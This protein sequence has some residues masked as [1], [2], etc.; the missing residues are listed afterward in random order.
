[1]MK[2]VFESYQFTDEIP[3]FEY[4]KNRK[5]NKYFSRE[6]AAAIVTCGK[7]LKGQE[8]DPEI[9]V[10]YATGVVEFEDYGLAKIVTAC[11]D[12]NNRYWPGSCPDHPPAPDRTGR[13]VR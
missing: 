4:L 2:V 3:V 5:L 6:T 1:M 7:L 11:S 10:Y 12:K 9:P 13:V 8:I